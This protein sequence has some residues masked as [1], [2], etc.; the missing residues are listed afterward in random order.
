MVSNKES[1][2]TR[3]RGDLPLVTKRDVDAC[4]PFVGVGTGRGEARP[5]VVSE[6]GKSAVDQAP[7]TPTKELKN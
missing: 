3:D 2:R 7:N 5:H 1:Q 6:G 4:S